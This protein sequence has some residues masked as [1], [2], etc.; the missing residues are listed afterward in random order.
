[1]KR[2]VLGCAGI[3]IFGVGLVLAGVPFGGDDTGFIPPDKTVGKCEG[4]V[5]KAVAKLVGAIVKCHALRVTGKLPGDVEE[6]ACEDTAR[7]K[8]AGTKTTGCGACTNLT[9]LSSTVETAVDDNNGAV[10]CDSAGAAF[11]SE[12][13][14][15]GFIPPDAPKGPITKCENGVGKAVSKLVAGIIKCHAT[16]A[17][18]KLADDAAEDACEDKLITK[19]NATKTKGCSACTALPALASTVESIL[20]AGNDL[21]YCQSPSGAFVDGM[22]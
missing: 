14:D 15:S 3:G 21:V 6:E 1:M 19:F 2:L 18:G 9:S 4:K 7:T 22:P 16:R 12:G 11:S 17:S 5:G 10:Y 13:D 8:F 20:D